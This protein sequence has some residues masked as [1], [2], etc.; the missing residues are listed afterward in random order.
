MSL[1]W[2][3]ENVRDHMEISPAQE[4]MDE[5]VNGGEGVKTHVL[6]LF[7]MVVGLG[8]ITEKNATEWWARVHLFEK[9]HGTMM[10][11]GGEPYNFTPQD[12]HRRI[13]LTVNVTPE[14]ATQWQ[15]RIFSDVYKNAMQWAEAEFREK[16][17]AA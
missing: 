9:L 10:Q 17:D 1:N 2:N 5:W 16:T 12:I 15:K 4:S 8:G 3:I 11:L 14:S 6:I 7:S 13:G